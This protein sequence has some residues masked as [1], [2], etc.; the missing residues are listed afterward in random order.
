[1][2]GRPVHLHSAAWSPVAVVA[3]LALLA[4]CA[5]TGH[6]TAC[7]EIGAISGVVFEFRPVLRAHHGEILLV[8]ACVKETCKSLRVSRHE[9]QHG[10]V[11]APDLIK[12]DS[13]IPVSLMISS[14]NGDIAYEGR[15]TAHPVKS[16]PNGPGCPPI[17]WSAQV[18]A[19]GKDKL[20]Q[21]DPPD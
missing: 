16:Q 20:R 10:M 2:K 18:F 4:G 8:R 3:G 6:A 17:T 14:P 9:R 1:V 11:V 19:S 13:P 21:I 12:D 5:G 7:T 15:L